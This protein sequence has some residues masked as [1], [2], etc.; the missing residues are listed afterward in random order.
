METGHRN[1]LSMYR[2]HDH[3]GGDRLVS[4]MVVRRIIIKHYQTN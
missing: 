2:H 3:T 4:E 1:I